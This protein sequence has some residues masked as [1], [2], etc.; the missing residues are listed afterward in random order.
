MKKTRTVAETEEREVEMFICDFCGSRVEEANVLTDQ[1]YVEIYER[2]TGPLS[3]LPSARISPGSDKTDTT[4]RD[5]ARIEEHIGHE[6][7]I[8]DPCVDELGVDDGD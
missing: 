4:H 3:R 6:Y 8:C 1:Y 7:D 5:Y 2:R